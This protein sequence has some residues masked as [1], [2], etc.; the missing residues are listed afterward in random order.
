[1][2]KQTVCEVLYVNKSA[3]SITLI[4][5]YYRSWIYPEKTTTVNVQLQVRQNIQYSTDIV[6]FTASGAY[7]ITHK[8]YIFIGQNV[9]M[10]NF[11]ICFTLF[12]VCL[13]DTCLL[14][15]SVYISIVF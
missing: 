9:S 10:K 2:C 14:Y 4:N 3:M 7:T 5:V 15:T 1:M 11:F 6:S 8:A 13:S 12:P